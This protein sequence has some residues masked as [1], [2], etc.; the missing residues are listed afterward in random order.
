M[1]SFPSMINSKET[2]T[3]L[4]RQFETIY[5][6]HMRDL[7]IVNARLKVEGV[8]FQPFDDHQLG[9]LVTPWFM[10]LVLLP[11][12][13]RWAAGAQ[14]SMTTLDFPSGKIDF[15]ITQDEELGTYLSA[16]LFRSVADI[17]DQAMARQLARHVMQNL[18]IEAKSE[19]S[20][21]RRDLLTGLRRS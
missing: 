4:V 6:E 8:A 14:G 17:P 9:V 12:T 21:S 1:S 2:V 18:F 15:A 16:V 19:R 5:D 3:A 7:P 20:L 10:N 11:A 13:D